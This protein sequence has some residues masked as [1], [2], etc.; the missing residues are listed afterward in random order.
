MTSHHQIERRLSRQIRVGRVAIGGGAPIAVQ[1]M[2]NTDTEDVAATVAQIRAA[3]KSGADIVRVSVPTLAAAK[4]FGEIKKEVGY[5][6]LVADIHFNYKCA[7]AAAE[8]GADCLRINPG[9]I[10]SDKKVSEVV[11]CARHHGVPIRIGVNAGSLEAE[12]Q[13]KYGEP[14]ADALVE[15]A[16]RHIEILKRHNFEDFKVSLKAS[17]VFLTVFAYRKLA[18]LIDQPLHLGITEAGGL[19]AGAVKSS[20][21]LGMLLA[22]G[23]GDT[24]RVSLAADPVEEV[25]VGWDILKSLHL[26]SR[27]INLVACPSCSRQNFDVIK[28]VTE[29]ES[30][31]DEVDEPLDLAV[32]GC[33]VNG[34]GE[35]REAAIGVAGGY[36][37]SIYVDGKIQHKAHNAELVDVLEKLVREKLAQRRAERAAA[38]DR[39]AEDAETAHS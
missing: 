18:R 30:R 15:S 25:K 13:E 24:I 38:V 5:V 14:N 28:A 4:A 10:G 23:I 36:P 33:V 32:I 39:N 22:D 3:V 27:G 16:L 26:R 20:I 34:P 9:N 12:L 37:N 8:A 1:T 35:A 7:L 29:L 11:A 2:T 31:F 21:G 6:P 19:R 17:E